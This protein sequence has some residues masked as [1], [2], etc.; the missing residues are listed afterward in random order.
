MLV[1]GDNLGSQLIGGFKEG[2]GAFLKCQH[3]MGTADEIKRMVSTVCLKMHIMFN[4][5]FV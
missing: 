2:P 3:C 5:T 4:T 1:S